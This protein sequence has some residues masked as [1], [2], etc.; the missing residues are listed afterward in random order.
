MSNRIN[1]DINYMKY[2]MGYEKGRVISEQRRVATK[3]ILLIEQVLPTDPEEIK[4]FQDYMDTI[5]PWVYNETDGKYYKLNKGGGYGTAGKNTKAAWRVYGAQY[6]QSLEGGAGA[7]I[8]PKTGKLVIAQT[9]TGTNNYTEPTVTIT[10]SVANNVTSWIVEGFAY[11][12]A[13]DT[14]SEVSKYVTKLI[15]EQIF[16]D[17]LLK[18][19]KAGTYVKL[20]SGSLRGG[21]SNSDGAPAEISFPSNDYKKFTTLTPTI[22]TKNKTAY[23]ANKKYAQNRA[24]NFWNYLVLNLPKDSD[25][26]S[27][28]VS[29]K[30]TVKT[31]GYIVDTGGV[32]DSNSKRNWDTN[33]IP[34]QQVYFKFAIQLLPGKEPDKANS[35]GCVWKSLVSFSYAGDDHSCDMATFDIYANSILIGTIDLGNGKLLVNDKTNFK[36]KSASIDGTELTTTEASVVGGA[37]SGTLKITGKDLAQEIVDASTTGEVVIS[38]VGKDEAFYTGRKF[39]CLSG[40]STHSDIPLIKATNSKGNIVFDARPTSTAKMPRCGATKGQYTSK[41]EKWILAKFNPCGASAAEGTLS[42]EITKGK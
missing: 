4:A 19:P 10:K 23:N 13:G 22:T 9:G 39:N 16:S 17:P 11:F 7:Q 2:L 1:E 30:A 14:K 28:Q 29:H 18:S 36:Y 6:I 31:E 26:G 25:G 24:T 12:T 5:G 35:V 3:N 41:C 33:P 27:V 32:T 37:V 34:G 21:A 15:K 8:D 20:I 42:K 40:C 38:A